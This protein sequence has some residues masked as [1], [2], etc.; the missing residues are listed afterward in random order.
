MNQLK[1]YFFQVFPE[2]DSL[3]SI[4]W[5]VIQKL[6]SEKHLLES[7]NEAQ[8][9]LRGKKLYAGRMLAIKI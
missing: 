4:L 7:N 2:T 8:I 3:L 1:T 9:T 6:S 5:T